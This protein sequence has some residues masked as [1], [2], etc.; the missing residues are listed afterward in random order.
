MKKEEEIRKHF[1]FEVKF[2]ANEDPKLQF[3]RKEGPDKEWH[4]VH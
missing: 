1:N 4:D 3:A 2:S